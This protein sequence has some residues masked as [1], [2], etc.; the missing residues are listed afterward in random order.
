MRK[1]AFNFWA[2]ISTHWDLQVKN[3]K[4]KKISNFQ[5]IDESN[6]KTVVD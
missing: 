4:K 3:Q 5:Y 6:G 1:F 2:L